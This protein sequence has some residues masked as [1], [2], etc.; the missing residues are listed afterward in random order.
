MILE[1]IRNVLAFNLVLSDCLQAYSIFHLLKNPYFIKAYTLWM[2]S[3]Y[4][5]ATCTILFQT[6]ANQLI[7][8]SVFSRLSLFG[9]KRNANTNTL[10]WETYLYHSFHKS[11][12]LHPLPNHTRSKTSWARKMEGSVLL[13]NGVQFQIP[14]TT[15][16]LTRFLCFAVS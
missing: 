10:T 3:F 15:R 7:C 12:H 13:L 4:T 8:S 16:W 5:Q 6:R 14:I 9:T 11:L 2:F 1:I